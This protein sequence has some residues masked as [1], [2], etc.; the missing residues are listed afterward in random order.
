MAVMTDNPDHI[1]ITD[2]ARERLEA[3]RDEGG[4]IGIIHN[5]KGAFP[6]QRTRN[7]ILFSPGEWAELMEW[8]QG[9]ARK[10]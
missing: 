1:I 8:G 2:N 5:T 7:V 3:K 9:I 4:I 6:D 10:S